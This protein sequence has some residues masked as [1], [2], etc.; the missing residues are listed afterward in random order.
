MAKKQKSPL[1]QMGHDARAA[2]LAG[3][4]RLKPFVMFPPKKKKGGGG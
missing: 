3:L 4:K 2:W 1:Q